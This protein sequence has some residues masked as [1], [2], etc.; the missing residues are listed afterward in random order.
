MLSYPRDPLRPSILLGRTRRGSKIPLLLVI[1]VKRNLCLT[2]LGLSRC[3]KTLN[4]D[5]SFTTRC[6]CGWPG[7]AL[8]G[9]GMEFCHFPL[10]TGFVCTMTLLSG[11]FPYLDSVHPYDSALIAGQFIIHDC[12]QSNVIF[13]IRKGIHMG[14]YHR[15]SSNTTTFLETFDDLNVVF[16]LWETE[17]LFFVQVEMIFPVVSSI[18][19]K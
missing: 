18:D 17:P 1:F 11:F 12:F 4:Y 7:V 16:D 9:E 14:W 5:W 19:W 6:G 13:I 15:L 2:K 8:W 3:A 10:A